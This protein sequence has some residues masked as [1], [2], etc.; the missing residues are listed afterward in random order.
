M[1]QFVVAL[2]LVL[3]STSL[4]YGQNT[5]LGQST[6][7]ADS[8]GQTIM[9]HISA[10]HLQT[11]CFNGVCSWKLYADTILN[12][13]KIE[14]SGVAI[15]TQNNYSLIRPGDY[16]MRLTKDIHNPDGTLFSQGYD[17]LVANGTVWH[18]FTSGISE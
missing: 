15:I 4:I 12:G 17:L 8:T 10:S 6:D 2:C 13:K 1:R 14:L 9:A 11:E 3:C 18:C 7:K 5:Q 16:Q